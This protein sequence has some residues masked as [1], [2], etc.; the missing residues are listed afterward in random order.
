MGGKIQNNTRGR[1]K[2][3]CSKAE[4]L[5]RDLQVISQHKNL[6]FYYSKITIWISQ[7]YFNC[8]C[9]GETN[10]VL[11]MLYLSAMSYQFLR[12]IKAEQDAIFFSEALNKIFS[13]CIVRSIFSWP[14]SSQALQL[15]IHLECD[16]DFIMIHL[17]IN[18]SVYLCSHHLI[19]Q[20]SKK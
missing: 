2:F 10:K 17:M 1:D 11:I 4:T 14:G 20:A 13:I 18:L 9:K 6:K 8:L 15:I 19:L 3:D 5:V 7:I 16:L 12:P